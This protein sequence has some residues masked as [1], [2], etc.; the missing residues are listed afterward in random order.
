MLPGG[1]KKDS[2]VWLHKNANMYQKKALTTD[3]CNVHLSDDAY[4]HTPE[5]AFVNPS[6]YITDEHGQVF[7]K[8]SRTWLHKSSYKK[9][10]KA[11]TAGVL[12]VSSIAG[13]HCSK[14]RQIRGNM[15]VNG[16]ELGSE[17]IGTRSSTEMIRKQNVLKVKKSKMAGATIDGRLVHPLDSVKEMSTN[18]HVKTPG[19]SYH[20]MKSVKTGS[21]EVSAY[22]S[23]FCI[24]GKRKSS[25]TISF[26]SSSSSDDVDNVDES[27]HRNKIQQCEL[28]SPVEFCSDNGGYGVE[29][30]YSSSQL[31][32]ARD[33]LRQL[34]KV[35][36][37][38]SRHRSERLT[39]RRTD[40][41]AHAVPHDVS[42]DTVSSESKV[43]LDACINLS[44]E[45]GCENS[46]EFN[47]TD[48][49]AQS[50]EQLQMRSPK[51]QTPPDL[52]RPAGDS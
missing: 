38:Q 15:N 3:Y 6:P 17:L 7:K 26:S 10:A 14:K 36:K 34:E 12:K 47:L 35:M 50:I 29:T 4:D 11:M 30:G 28:G 25:I 39:L 13:K 24:V 16:G 8:D 5:D 44:D 40:D 48:Q 51:R 22:A 20:N 1:F 21:C 19:G 32:I 27:G 33:G 42:P 52:T 18:A 23:D 2:R 31:E 49:L 43:S 37:E 41:S 46:Q 9:L 45:L